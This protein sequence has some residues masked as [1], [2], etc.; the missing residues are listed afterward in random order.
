ME[1]V[2]NAINYLQ[3]SGYE[4]GKKAVILANEI[5][6]LDR[7][8]RRCAVDK[9]MGAIKHA[10]RPPLLKGI[11]HSGQGE[12]LESLHFQL[13]NPDEK[14][15]MESFLASAHKLSESYTGYFDFAVWKIY[16]EG[17]IRHYEVYLCS[18]QNNEINPC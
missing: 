18:S 14:S 9:I 15:E 10:E 3:F 6:R 4:V 11:V 5:N 12:I 7:I 16:N 1:E 17:H 13:S 8:R 2:L